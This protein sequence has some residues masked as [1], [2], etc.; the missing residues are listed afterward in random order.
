MKEVSAGFQLYEISRRIFKAAHTES[1]PAHYQCRELVE[2]FYFTINN[3]SFKLNPPFW[4]D[5]ASIPQFAWS[6]IGNPWEQ[7]V[8]PGALVHDCLYATQ[9]FPREICDEIFFQIN[10]KNGMGWFKNHTIYRS[11]RMGGGSAWKEKTEKHIVKCREHLEINNNP[12]NKI[13]FYKAFVEL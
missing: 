4:W 6:I 5:G 11:V 12:I 8:A 10:K 13:Y 7:D 3:F 1:N 2:P 9:I